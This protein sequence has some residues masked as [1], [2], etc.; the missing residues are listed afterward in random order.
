MVI[1]EHLPR[2]VTLKY[3]MVNPG[4][5]N[6]DVLLFTFTILTCFS[7]VSSLSCSGSGVLPETKLYHTSPTS[8]Y[9]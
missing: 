1:G 9:R 6:F 8:S 2:M 3:V 7:P 4:Q 5:W